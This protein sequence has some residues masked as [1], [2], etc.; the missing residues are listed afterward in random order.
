[1][2][3][4][5]GTSAPHQR[6]GSKWSVNWRKR[7]TPIREGRTLLSSRFYSRYAIRTGVRGLFPEIRT[8]FLLVVVKFRFNRPYTGERSE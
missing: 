6:A 2:L 7:A 4:H 8:P 1:M 5:F 3:E